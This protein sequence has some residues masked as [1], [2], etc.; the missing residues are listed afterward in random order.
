MYYFIINPCSGS[1]RGRKVWN[2]VERYLLPR[3]VEYR[4]FL[5]ERP[6][7]ATEFAQQLTRGSR[8]PR[9]I[10]VVEIGRAHV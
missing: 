2:K 4:V 3:G 6:G 1:G 7:Q 5:T 8:D 10:V 9:L